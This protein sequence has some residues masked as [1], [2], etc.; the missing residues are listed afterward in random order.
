[1]TTESDRQSCNQLER[2]NLT[3]YL[4]FVAQKPA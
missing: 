2:R 4:V 3:D 1:M